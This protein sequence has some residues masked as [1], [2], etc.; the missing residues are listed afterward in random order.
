MEAVDK[1]KVL[2][3]IRSNSGENV[4]TPGPARQLILELKMRHVK[5]AISTNLINQIFKFYEKI[6]R[7]TKFRP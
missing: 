1:F 5:I 7:R 3:F 4:C 2:R 6:A